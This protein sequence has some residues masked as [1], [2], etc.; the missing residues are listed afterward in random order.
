M[1]IWRLGV[2]V[3]LLACFTAHAGWEYVAV[4]KGEGGAEAAQ[5]NMTVR[6]LVEGPKARVEFVSSSNPMMPAGSYILTH[7]GG[8]TMYLVTPQQRSYAKWDLH[9][10]LGFAGSAMQM[11]NIKFSQPKVEKLAEEKG[12]MLLG[13]PTRYYRFR[14]TYTVSM[15]FLGM[16]RSTET[17][18]DEEIWTTEELKDTGFQAWLNQKPPQSGNAE[19]DKLI[20]AEVGKV[21]GFPIK[22]VATTTQREADGSTQTSRIIFEVTSLANKAVPASAFDLPQG[23]TERS[24]LNS[25]APFSSDEDNEDESPSSSGGQSSPGENPFLKLMQQMQQQSR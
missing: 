11:M 1:R 16:Q 6:G 7:D 17:I 5:A 21:K 8:H 20:A 14:T 22:R 9:A 25:V 13:Y 12:P 10:M 24:V 4:T 18:Q 3:C 15:N 2:A 23:Y 19:L